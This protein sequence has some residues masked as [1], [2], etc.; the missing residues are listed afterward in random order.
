MLSLI[1]FFTVSF[2]S[3]SV[4]PPATLPEIRSMYLKANDHEKIC[5]E[6]LAL[7]KPYDESNNPLFL[8]YKAGANMIMAKHVKNPISKMSWF[9][10]GKKMLEAAIKADTK[11]VELRCLR[12]GIQS[13]VP[14]FLNYK[15]NINH[16]KKFIL[17]SYPHVKDPALKKNIISYMTKWGDLTAAEK[18]MLK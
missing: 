9:N 3:A 1:F 4:P 10:K 16:D 5:K 11:D 12:F 17:Q 2:S 8:G 14:S 7:L 18:E 13:N 6:M 15:E